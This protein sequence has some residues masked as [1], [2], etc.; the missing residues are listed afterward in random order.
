MIILRTFATVCLSGLTLFQF[1]AISQEKQKPQNATQSAWSIP[2]L[3]DVKKTGDEMVI[4][5]KRYQLKNGLTVLIH[6]DHSDP[7]CYVDVTYH[8]GS[9][10]EQQGRS[11]FAHFFEHMM[12]QGS[13]HVADEQHFK[14]ITEAGGTLNGTTNS[15]R[16][17]YFETVPSNQLEKM[18][19]L[20][21]DRMGFLLDSVTQR[22]F[23]VQRATVKNERG[24]RYDNAPY[25][26]VSEKIGEALYPQ[27]HPYSWTTIGYI[28]DLNRVDVGDLKRFYMRWYGPNNALLTV[29]GDVNTKD[30][31]VLAQKYFGSIQR[32]PEVRAQKIEPVVLDKSRYISYE[33]NVKFPMLNLAFA[34]AAINTADDAALDVLSEIL[35]GNQSSPLYKGFIESK[36]AVSVNTYQYSRELAGQFQMVIRANQ[37]ALLAETEAEL[38]KILDE[39][40]TKGVTDDD[41][42][43]FRAG[44]QS[45]LFNQL[46]TVQGKGALLASNF[47][48]A[49]NANNLKEEY[50]RYMS[51]SKDDVMRVYRTYLKNKPAVILSC[52]PKGKPEL[53]A[54][55]DTWTMY[56]RTIETE[57]AEYKNLSYTEPKDN[58]SRALIPQA[59]VAKAVPV[60]EFYLSKIADRIPLIGVQ[61]NETPLVNIQISLKAGHRYETIDK[62]G[63]SSLMAA[64]WQ[65]STLKTSSEEIENKFARLGASLSLNAGDDN[66][67]F[68]LQSPKANLKAAVELL[69]EMMFEPKFD[70]KEFELEKK[71]QMDAITQ[72]QTN[73]SVLA[74]NIYRKLIY[75]ASHV[76]GNPN[77]GTSE[78]LN[79][80]SLDD[81]KA[82]YASL[83]S[84]IMSIAVSGAASREEILGHLAFLGNFQKGPEL[85]ITESA[86]PSIEKTKIYFADKKGAAQSEIRIGY[87]AMPYDALGEFY[88]ANIM[89]FSFAGAF[90]SR[91]NYLLRE[92]KGW[93]YG[94]RGSFSGS[95]FA[96]PYTL[97]GAFKANATDSTISEMF[98]EL[99]NYS[100][101][102]IT[103]EELEFTRK[104]MAQS[105]A[106][107]YESPIQKLGFIK[108]VLDYDLSRDYVARQTKMLNA[109]TET[110]INAL[111]KKHLPYTKMVIIV[112]GDKASLYEKL[113]KLPY[114]V[115]EV[116]L[117]GN[118][119]K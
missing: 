14:L 69:K 64:L 94:T 27:G 52:L 61:E 103:K 85:K 119:I 9:A 113:K 83:N 26:L 21:A 92:I 87:M 101:N 43:R 4:P 107:K 68:F 53:K 65:K 51:V 15:D 58:F 42:A 47:T 114:E 45:N 88:K 93:T 50:K 17:N 31:L 37:G 96:G 72:S 112:V 2:I 32:G 81:V 95:A 56:T 3:E 78:T 115:V 100:D 49:K 75:G 84:N 16:T 98:N 105:D 106:L 76:M 97:S 99:K 80:I 1:P 90:N 33:D 108:R 8:V 19:W 62:S 12:F 70:E 28:E 86:I 57:S 77:L 66:I 36:K 44:Y 109:I 111:A 6:E 118:P 46:S 54:S 91:T 13:K 18:L 24:Q 82:C 102:G 110:E 10:R 89:N 7:M 71:K 116:D 104:A 11:G 23:E 39:W 59:T 30:V 48:L 117:S 79:S 73:A 35:S 20:E 5:Y 38:R 74:G 22:K 55:N 25:G 40:E 67:T 41:I 60:P 63:V 29:A 34:S